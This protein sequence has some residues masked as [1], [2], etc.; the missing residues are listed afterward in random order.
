MIIGLVVGQNSS[1]R[2]SYS[3]FINSWKKELLLLNSNLDIRVYPDEISD[4]KDIDLL[5][6]QKYP[7]GILNQ[8]VNARAIIV[9][10]AGIDHLLRDI[11][12]PQLPIVRIVDKNMARDL[13][14][15]AVGH[16]L[17]IIKRTEHWQQNQA[18]K[19]W[20]KEYPFNY[21]NKTVGIMGLGQIGLKIV[22]A[23][24]ALDINVVGWSKSPKNISRMTCYHGNFE[25]K[26]FLNVTDILI[27]VLPLTKETENIIDDK[28]LREL[29]SGVYVINIG[30][31]MHVVD[32]DLLEALDANI[33]AGAVLDVFRQE[34][35]P[36]THP[37][38]EHSK[39]K[40]TPHIASISNPI[41]AAPQVYENICR[42]Q[43][44][45]DL[46]NLVDIIKGY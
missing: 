29:K 37:F 46:I 34:P 27:C 20:A 18:K 26:S 40:L 42:L 9:L 19:N 44:N 30:R 8:F 1:E 38:W 12:L 15:Y 28:L 13:A 17:N 43:E 10:A 35:L 3:S 14:Q 36:S 25:I 41:T 23:L 6:V 4:P 2:E 45:R 31:G 24:K 21:A 5:L 22:D 16:V 39:M 7:L 11:S 33:L 32:E